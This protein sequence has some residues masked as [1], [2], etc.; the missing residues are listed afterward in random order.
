MKSVALRTK[1]ITG[2][3]TGGMLLS[4][5]SLAF[6]TGIKST[7]TDVKTA[8]K[9]EV[10][11]PKADALKASEQ[12]QRDAQR[13]KKLD[14]KLAKLV[15]DKTITQDQSDKIKAAIASEEAANKV[16]KEKTKTMTNSER[17]SYIDS[18]KTT[19][20]SALKVLVDAGT[21][22]QAQADKVGPVGAIGGPGKHG[23]DMKGGVKLESIL[24]LGVS[25]N[26]ITQSESDKVLSYENSKTVDKTVK[27]NI[28][29][30]LVDNNILT[31][32]KVEA[33]KANE[34][35]Q[36]DTQ[37]QAKMDTKL[38]KL[39]TDKT[40][41]QDQSDKI[42]VAIVTQEAVNKVEMEKIKTMTAA[43]RKSYRESKKG[44]HISALKAL[45]NAGTITQAQAD[46]VGH[47]ANNHM[48]GI[49]IK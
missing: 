30:D 26:I 24:K 41:T 25:S 1:I 13:Q 20:I 14:T 17:K 27:M 47:G 43:E 44:T 39:V 42:K 19:H 31:Q 21:I 35:A 23:K 18:N 28:Y 29:K 36:M 6:A 40:I 9:I 37:R 11:Q 12:V 7:K 5:V 16:E 33:L 15:T 34:K 8:S 48:A 3:I 38:A 49:K 45:V 10:K 4:S 46:K 22:T 32:A 2:I